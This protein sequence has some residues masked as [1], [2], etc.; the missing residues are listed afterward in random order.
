[1]LP[2]SLLR[3]EILGMSIVDRRP[4]WPWNPADLKGSMKTC[5]EGEGWGGV[6]LLMILIPLPPQTEASRREREAQLRVDVE[7]GH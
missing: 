7:W 4:Q 1:M 5:C 2:H 3:P 6:S